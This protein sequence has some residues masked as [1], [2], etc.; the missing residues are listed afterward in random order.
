MLVNN[1]TEVDKLANAALIM[2]NYLFLPIL[3]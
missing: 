3:S 2:A 1:G